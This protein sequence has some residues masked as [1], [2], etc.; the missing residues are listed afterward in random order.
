MKFQPE[1]ELVFLWI[2]DGNDVNSKW[3]HSK[4]VLEFSTHFNRKSVRN[5][6][7]ATFNISLSKFQVFDE[8]TR[9][10]KKDKT[11]G[12]CTDEG[13]KP[14]TRLQLQDVMKLVEENKQ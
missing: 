1:C 6:D 2:A 14:E 5:V 13:Q 8:H 10:K 9:Q 4:L 11:L 3:R 12:H 7:T